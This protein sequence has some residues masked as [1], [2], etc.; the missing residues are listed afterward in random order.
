MLWFQVAECFQFWL[1]S[2]E[3]FLFDDWL[4]VHFSIQRKIVEYSDFI[5]TWWYHFFF[6]NCMFFFFFG[7]IYLCLVVWLSHQIHSYSREKKKFKYQMNTIFFAISYANNSVTC[8]RSYFL[9]EVVGRIPIFNNIL[10]FCGK[11]D[12]VH[13][14]VS[15]LL[16]LI[17]I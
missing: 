15:S 4:F 1:H 9:F 10:V 7:L 3:C 2:N 17:F 8:K 6:L 16:R 12:L 11:L 13:S 5:C 14:I